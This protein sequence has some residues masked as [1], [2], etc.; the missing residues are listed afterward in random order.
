MTDPTTV[1]RWR[2]GDALRAAGI[3]H[4]R[5]ARWLDR[6]VV[7]LRPYDIDTVGTGSPRLFSARRVYQFAII[8][9]LGS[10]G[11]VADRAS[12]A[13]LAFTD[14]RGPG[15]EACRLFADCPMFAGEP[16]WLLVTPAGDHVV[17]PGDEAARRL[18]TSDVAPGM[19]GCLAILDLDA[20]VRR[21]DA[22][23]NQESK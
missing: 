12:R 11:I 1:P 23:L 9:E 6:G 7:T 8:A 5:L 15:R 2:F 22:A 3:S 20:L 14:Q 19:P 21:V 17:T 16:T 18:F 4:H 13:A 10:L